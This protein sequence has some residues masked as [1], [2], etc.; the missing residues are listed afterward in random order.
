MLKEGGGPIIG[1]GPKLGVLT[2]Q[3]RENR[4]R[5]RPLRCVAR[6]VA[7]LAQEAGSRG[8]GSRGVGAC[9]LPPYLCTAGL[10]RRQDGES[11]PPSGS[12]LRGGR[13]G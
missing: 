3:K 11:R 2:R 1:I 9:C 8:A 5:G 6:G 4:M 7:W 10:R 13:S 12:E